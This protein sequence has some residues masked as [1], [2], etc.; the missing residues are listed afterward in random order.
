M[1]PNKKKQQKSWV[2]AAPIFQVNPSTS[3]RKGTHRPGRATSFQKS[4]A[5]RIFFQVLNT[6]HVI[7][8]VQHLLEVVNASADSQ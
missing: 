4:L 1:E 3:S 6:N 2:D 5:I 7:P 8:C